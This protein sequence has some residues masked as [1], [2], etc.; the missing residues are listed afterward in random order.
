MYR[1]ILTKAII[2]K[3]EKTIQEEQTV[4]V[5]VP[6][7]KVLGCWIIN[8]FHSIKR[9]NQKVF[10]KGTYDT[11]FWYGYNNDTSCGLHNQKFEYCYEIPYTFTQETI[12]L[13]DSNEIKETVAKNPTCISMKFD[14][15][16]MTIQVEFK[17]LID[18]IGETK[19]KIKVD[20]VII[21]QMIN[22]DYVKENK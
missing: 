22:T 1:E 21:D 9:E 6:V 18:I 14:N 5:D 19:L 8:H 16:T 10:I 2:A 12:E 15:T 11:Y 7:S 3:G 4:N 20:D 13:N 17:F